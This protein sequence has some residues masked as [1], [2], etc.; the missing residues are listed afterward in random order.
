MTLQPGCCAELLSDRSQV[1]SSLNRVSA[2][3]GHPVLV[4]AT[5]RLLLGS[6]PCARRCAT[7]TDPHDTAAADEVSM[8]P[9]YT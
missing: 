5:E 1:K 4:L 8:F 3:T 7:H 9:V 6:L 2:P